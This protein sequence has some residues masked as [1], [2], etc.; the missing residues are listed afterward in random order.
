MSTPLDSAREIAAAIAFRRSTRSLDPC[1]PRA[2]DGELASITRVLLIV[3]SI[4]MTQGRSF[5]QWSIPAQTP[6]L[7]SIVAHEVRGDHPRTSVTPGSL[8]QVP[9]TP[10]SLLVSNAILQPGVEGK[11]GTPATES[12]AYTPLSV[13]CKFRLFRTTTYSPYTFLSAGFQAT[14]DQAMGQWPQYGGGMQGWAKR[15]GATLAD[16]ESRRFIQGF[17]LSTILHQDPRYFPS[18]RR[19]LISRVWYSAT[20]VVVTKSDHGD[21]PFNSSEFLGALLASSLQNA[22]YPRHDRNVGETMNRFGGALSS[23]AI[24]DLLR[25][26]T[27]DM[28]RLFRKHAPKE[29]QKIEERLPIPP[30]DKP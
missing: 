19:S 3:I 10:C 8:D 27:P 13:R 25:E 4:V 24:G 9:T 22:Y 18:H 16:T 6:A 5:A 17:A 20:R 12:L 23:D 15:F 11:E 7:S 28:K 2:L 30:E 1:R 21:T 14:W 26:F 29:I